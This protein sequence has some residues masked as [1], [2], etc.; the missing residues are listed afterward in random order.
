MNTQDPLKK[1][2]SL[3]KDEKF[4]YA[5][6]PGNGKSENPRI[7]V[8][9]GEDYLKRQRPMEITAQAQYMKESTQSAYWRIQFKVPFPFGMS[10]A[11]AQQVG[12]LLLFLNQMIE[13]PGFELHEVDNL[14]SFRYVLLTAPNSLDTILLFSVIGNIMMLLDVFTETIERVAEGKSTFNDLLEEA[15]KLLLRIPQS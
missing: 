10:D 11:T 9:I 2:E 5:P 4:D 15:S 14:A 3:L 6:L 1:I 7:L 13:L 8:Y 12:S